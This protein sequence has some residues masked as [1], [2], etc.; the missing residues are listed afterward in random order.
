MKKSIYFKVWIIFILSF[1]GLARASAQQFLENTETVDIVQIPGFNNDG[2]M[3][4]YYV[5]DLGTS[6][7]SIAWTTE[8]GDITKWYKIA[9]GGVSDSTADVQAYYYKNVATGRYLYISDAIQTALATGRTGDWPTARAGASATNAK[10]ANFKWFERTSPWPWGV[11]LTN[12]AGIDPTQADGNRFNCLTGIILMKV[13]DGGINGQEFFGV[14]EPNVSVGGFKG[15]TGNAWTA[16]KTPVVVQTGVLNP[17]IP[18]FLKKAKTVDII[19]IT[20]WMTP[21]NAKLGGLQPYVADSH[22][23]IVY[24]TDA[25]AD[26]TKWYQIP[27]DGNEFGQQLYYYKN[28]ATGAYLKGSTIPMGTGDWT[29][30]AATTSTTNDRSKLFKWSKMDSNWGNGPWLVNEDGNTGTRPSGSNTKA[31]FALTMLTANSEF[32]GVDVPNVAI[33]NPHD[34]GNA[35]T[36]VKIEVAATGVANPD[37]RVENARA[38]DVIQISTWMTPNNVKLGGT[39]P[40]ASDSHGL[41]VYSTDAAADSTKWY[42]IPAGE[43]AFGQQIYY[44]KNL[45]TGAYLKGSTIPMGTGDWTVSAATTSATNDGSASLKWSKMDSNWGNGPWLVNE[46]GNTGARPSGSNKNAFFAFTMLTANSE[47]FGVDVPNVAI[48]NTSDGSNAWTAV[49]INVAASGVT[50]PDY[51]PDGSFTYSKDELNFFAT[52]NGEDASAASY[53][54]GTHTISYTNGGWHRAGWNWE[55]DG[56]IDAS[57]YNQVWIKFDASALPKTGD[58]VGGATKLQ[59]DVVYMDDS[60][61]AAF[62]NKTNEIHSNDTAYFYNL[63]PGKKIKRITLKSEVQ[64]DVVLTGAYFFN[65]GIDPV[66]LIVTDISWTPENPV[67]TDSILFSATIKNQSKFA[68]QN[69]KHG[70]TFSVKLPTASGNGTIVAWSDTHL[71]SLA[72]GES[73]TVTANGG[74]KVAAKW[75]FGLAKTYA[76]IANVNDQKDV[77][78]SDYSNNTFTKEIVIGA[79]TGID[80]ISTDG[81]VYVA[82]SKLYVVNYPENT[83]VSIYNLQAQEIGHYLAREVSGLALPKNL[84]ILKIQEGNKSSNLKVLIR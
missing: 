72:P 44:Y 78:E 54:A 76:V 65:K 74:P 53:N 21:N 73:V 15:G 59:F 67:V 27:A 17:D 57:A 8:T 51:V 32:F 31:F 2:N 36:A 42:E 64:G 37:Y 22:G 10:T 80:E 52:D 25:A 82:D 23:S 14:Y 39:K 30:S 45:A 4:Q 40:Y 33:S 13:N 47:F 60:N 35:W 84:Y 77:L 18:H 43:G 56:G 68:S 83:L 50:N 12:A 11:Y 81:R 48:S 49:Q 79:S 55:A 26:S 58:G 34:G 41:V 71:T 62:D 66:D 46:D 1:V 24:S 28:V 70:V 19:Q 61:A 9:A 6:V 5:A 63:T 38:V 7:D 29:V 20:T 16:L 3:A 69:V 75:K